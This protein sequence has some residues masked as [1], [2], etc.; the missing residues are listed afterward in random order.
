M[1][2]RRFEETTLIAAGDAFQSVTEWHRRVPTLVPETVA[3]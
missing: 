2:G 3:A 1:G